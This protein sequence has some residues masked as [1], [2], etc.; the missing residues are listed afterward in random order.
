MME[1]SEEK[2]GYNVIMLIFM[3]LCI[4]I[5]VVAGVKGLEAINVLFFVFGLICAIF[6]ASPG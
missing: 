3:F 5:S 4:V 2:K 6:I 1:H